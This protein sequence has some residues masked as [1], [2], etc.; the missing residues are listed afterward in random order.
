[1]AK[2]ERSGKPPY[3]G[4]FNVHSRVMD[5]E[6]VERAIKR[7]AHEIIEH[8]E[9]LDD[10]CLVGLQTG[11]VDFADAIATALAKIGEK[12][13]PTGKLDVALY[14][15]DI[16]I[17]PILPEAETE[18]TFDIG[19]KKVVLV[20]DVLFTGRT[21]RS[22]MDALMDVGRPKSIQLAVMIDRGHRELPVR[23]DYVGKN[24]P[25]RKGEAVNATLDGVDLGETLR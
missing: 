21:V 8:N 1:M 23:P 12:I 25:T 6:A 7:I 11:G 9:G 20:D 4:F 5:A 2:R 17:R 18:I 16:N 19:R 10:V 22:A 13:V 14:R 15:D 24:L 3:G